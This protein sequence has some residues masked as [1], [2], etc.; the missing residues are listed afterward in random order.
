MD[1]QSP[2]VHRSLKDLVAD[3]V[4]TI[5]VLER[6]GFD[7][8]CHGHH[9]LEQAAHARG[10]SLQDVVDALASLG[11]PTESGYP[12]EWHDLAALTRH[13]VEHHHGYIRAITPTIQGW[14]QKLSERH[15]TRHP[16]LD[17]VRQAFEQLGDDLSTHMA[18]EEAILFP[19]IDDL[20]AASRAGGSLPRG[21]FATILHPVRM[22][23][24]EHEMAEEFLE[25]LRALTNGYTPPDDGCT[26]FRLC[27]TE[28]QRF[29]TDLHRHV[30]LENNLLFPRALELEGRLS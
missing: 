23:E 15:R 18:K 19:Y 5:P 10:A 2:I 28:L 7:Y 25:R 21:P 17:D 6:Y 3:D 26:T 13:I 30:H 9:T 1:T 20:A 12:D 16:E 27:Y 14:L 4:R 24:A 22:M 29:E 11:E 8:C